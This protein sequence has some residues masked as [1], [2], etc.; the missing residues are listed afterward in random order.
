DKEL[1]VFRDS[2]GS[3]LTP[4]LI[5]YYKKITLIDNRYIHS[6]YYLNK[7]DFKNQDILFMY[8]TLLVNNSGSLKG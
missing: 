8:S 3:S 1:V 7:V 5:N 6:K 4:L 2:F